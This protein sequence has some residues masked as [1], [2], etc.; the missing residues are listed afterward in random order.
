MRV[1]QERT[2]TGRAI[3]T[4]IAVVAVLSLVT[5]AK[6]VTRELQSRPANVEHARNSLL[7]WARAA[8]MEIPGSHT[9]GE[10][11]LTPDQAVF[12][13]RACTVRKKLNPITDP[14]WR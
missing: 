3:V 13:I 12:V 5:G 2:G 7:S 4:S 10:T 1:H 6:R 14:G 9:P 11:R 8:V